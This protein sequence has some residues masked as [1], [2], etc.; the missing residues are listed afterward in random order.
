[1]RDGKDILKENKVHNFKKGSKMKSL[2][3]FGRIAFA[4]FAIATPAPA[5]YPIVKGEVRKLD[6]NSN[7]ISIK[8]EAIP[9]LNM[10]PMTMSFLAQEPHLLNGLAVGDKINFVADEI[11]DELTVLWLEK[12][13]VPT[14]PIVKG[15]VKKIDL[16]SGR[17]SIKH[18][19][20]PN[21]NMPGM[22]MSFL[23]QDPK[24]LTG[25][26]VGENIN[27]TADEIDGDLTVLWLEKSTSHGQSNTEILCTGIAPT[28]PKTN[29]EIEIRAKKFSTIRYEFAEGPY[30]GT[31]Y[32]NSI[33]QMVAKNDGSNYLYTSGEGKLATSLSFETHEN[34]ISDAH[35]SHYS[36]G[37]DQALVQ[38]S[39]Q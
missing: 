27:F 6:T 10:A 30:K 38:C 25:L 13:V 2:L 15:V 23:V 31:A 9:N 37:M 1:M 24:Y 17:I 8:H 11:D 32:I 4:Q 33:G 35:F 22:T 21:L 28:T 3:L 16:V 29:V 20:I 14:L 7:R 34:R 18:E 5:G 12:Q 26:S 36:S 19:A 39:F